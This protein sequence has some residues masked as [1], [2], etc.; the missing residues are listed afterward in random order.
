MKLPKELIIRIYEY[1]KPESKY[2]FIK[3]FPFLEELLPECDNDDCYKKI[4]YEMKEMGKPK[5]TY[6]ICSK[7]CKTY[8]NSFQCTG[9]SFQNEYK[10]K[11]IRFEYQSSFCTPFRGWCNP[12]PDITLIGYKIRDI[13]TEKKLLHTFIRRN[14]IIKKI[15]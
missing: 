14:F 2:N 8:Q 3:V 4:C 13:N 6:N 11:L 7:Y 15:A 1:L 12:V 10:N 9:L 5:E